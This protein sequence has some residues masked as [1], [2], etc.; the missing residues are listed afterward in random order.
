MKLESSSVGLAAD[1]HLQLSDPS[2]QSQQLLLKSRLLSFEG[3]YLL[4]DS[5]VFCLLEVK[6]SFPKVSCILHFFL[7]ADELVR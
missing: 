3:S 6:V 7:D 2:L 4:L 1:L 5:A